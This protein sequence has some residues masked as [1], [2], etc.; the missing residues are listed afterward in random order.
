MSRANNHVRQDK[1]DNIAV[2]P[3]FLGSNR[4][5]TLMF[6]Q[7]FFDELRRRVPVRWLAYESNESGRPEIYVRPFPAAASGDGGKW[8]VSNNGGTWPIWP[9][10]SREIFYRSGDQV[11]AVPYTAA[12]D[13]FVPEKP[14]VVA[15]TPGAAPGFDVAPDGRVLLMVPTQSPGLTNVCVPNVSRVIESRSRS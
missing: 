11:M 13:S 15:A 9:A 10:K 14:R 4:E 12:A 5:H 1:E 3:T 7:N 2:V 6:V 8:Q